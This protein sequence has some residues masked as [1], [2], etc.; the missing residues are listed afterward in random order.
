MVLIAIDPSVTGEVPTPRPARHRPG[1]HH[2]GG[3]LTDGEAE[4]AV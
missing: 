3:N 4:A 2:S 1:Q